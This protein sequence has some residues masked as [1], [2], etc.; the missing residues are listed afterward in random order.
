MDTFTA[1]VRNLTDDDTPVASLDCV[2]FIVTL[3][4]TIRS[5][6]MAT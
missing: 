5:M 3:T 6:P 1:Y 4:S 2:N